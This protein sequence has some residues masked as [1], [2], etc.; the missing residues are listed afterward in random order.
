MNNLF[1]IIKNFIEDIF[2]DIYNKLFSS[3]YIRKG[4][5]KKCGACC[6]NILF[7]TEEGYVKSEELFKQ[8]QK[9]YKY[10]R[11]FKIS[12]VIKDKQD[13]QNGALTFECK[14]IT[15]DNKCRIYYLR[16]IFCRKYPDA[17][18]E[19]IYQ[20]VT[21]LDECGYYFDIDKKFESY[22]EKS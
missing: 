14:H 12:G 9:K 22:L 6:R 20:G 10:Y 2:L 5:C 15:K 16:P 8:M 11:N 21:M 17:I 7:S 3:K 19:L 4:K 18:Q 1:K 13:F